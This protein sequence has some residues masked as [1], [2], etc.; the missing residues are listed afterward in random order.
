M[1]RLVR[2]CGAN[3]ALPLLQA[4]PRRTVNQVHGHLQADLLG[5]G[6]DLR[7]VGRRVG[8]VEYLQH[9]GDDGLHAEGDAGE[10]AFLEG[11]QVFA[12]DGVWVRFGGDFCAFDEAEYVDGCLQD[13][14]EVAGGQFGGGA[15]AEENGVH[16]AF[17]DAGGFE[18]AGGEEDFCDGVVGVGAEADAVAEVFGGVGVEVA[19][20]AAYGAEGDVYVEAE[21][22]VFASCRAGGG[23]APVA[24]CGGAGGLGGHSAS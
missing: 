8:A 21:V 20:A 13:A 9:L 24:G 3:A 22:A 1:V 6:D 23:D 16:G 2:D 19:V 14:Y 7:H 10:A 17:C 12:G 18:G 4:L 15:A 11:L 5:P